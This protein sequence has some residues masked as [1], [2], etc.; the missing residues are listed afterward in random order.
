MSE[1]TDTRTWLD[2]RRVPVALALVVLIVAGAVIWLQRQPRSAIVIV[3]PAVPPEGA[4]SP[5]TIP[6]LDLNLATRAELESLPGIGPV[7]AQRIIDYRSE[8]GALARI[9]ELIEAKLV[10]RATFDRV[11]DQ[12]TVG[13]SR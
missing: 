13:A 12:V 9:D 5:V 11:K 1:A 2:R 8:H 6:P 10:T 7:T 3:P 4:T